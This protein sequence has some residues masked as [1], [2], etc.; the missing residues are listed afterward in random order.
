[1]VHW[2]GKQFLHLIL[3]DDFYTGAMANEQAWDGS[4]YLSC[5]T[6]WKQVCF[7]LNKHKS[8]F[9]MFQ[10]TFIVLSLSVPDLY[11][12]SMY[13]FV[14]VCT[15]LTLGRSI[16]LY[17]Q[18]F[19]RSK[20]MIFLHGDFPLYEHARSYKKYTGCSEAFPFCHPYSIGDGIHCMGVCNMWSSPDMSLTGCSK[21][22]LFQ[23]CFRRG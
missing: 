16:N 23:Y 17:K 2:K 14:H 18:G 22:M 8:S 1:M 4:L 3:Q 11:P 19:P 10:D 12:L 20:H 21:T 6:M 13:A 7:K 5:A 15:I 9:N